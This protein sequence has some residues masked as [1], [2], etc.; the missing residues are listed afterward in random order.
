MPEVAAEDNQQENSSRTPLPRLKKT[1]II[2]PQFCVYE[3]LQK[4]LRGIAPH[5]EV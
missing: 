1:C 3:R 4:I 5:Q 2:S